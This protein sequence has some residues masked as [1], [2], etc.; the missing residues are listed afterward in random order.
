[1]GK[2]RQ[3]HRRAAEEKVAAAQQREQDYAHGNWPAL[4]G[5]RGLAA[6]GVLVFHLYLLGGKPTFPAPV[7]WLLEMGW[8]GVDV[9]FT[10][11]AFLLS[12]P[13]VESIERGAPKPSLRQYW[14]HRAWRVLPA[15]WVQ[16]SFLFV[17]ALVGAK[18]S[19][20]VNPG[21]ASLAV[22]ALFLYDLHPYVP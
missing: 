6:A 20:W 15:Y 2:S 8:S 14:S 5:L 12:L 16:V 7:A 11:S 10:L 17:L 21:A 3:R 22:H 1:M 19:Y 13:F 18:V 4:T 9:F